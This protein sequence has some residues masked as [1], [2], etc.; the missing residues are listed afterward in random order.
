M[1]FKI[2]GEPTFLIPDTKEAFNRL[3]QVFIKASIL[4][5]FDLE[6]HI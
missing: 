4:W 1:C 6:Y 2:I 3:R 5:H